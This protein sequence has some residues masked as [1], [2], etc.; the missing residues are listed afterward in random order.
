M[1]CFFKSTCFRNK[2]FRK[3]CF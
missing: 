3:F 1:K 2:S